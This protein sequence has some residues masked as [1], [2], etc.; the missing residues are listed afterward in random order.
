MIF[1]P[2]STPAPAFVR[3]THYVTIAREGY[4]DSWLCT[5]PPGLE[6]DDLQAWAEALVKLERG[7]HGWTVTVAR[8]GKGR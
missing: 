3:H 1:T 5:P 8:A 4:T 2:S 6:G 7:D